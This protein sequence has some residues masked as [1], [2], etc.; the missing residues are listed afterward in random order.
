M[1]FMAILA[2]SF[3]VCYSNTTFSREG[4][5]IAKNHR[6][7]GTEGAKEIGTL[8]G[9][10]YPAAVF[11]SIRFPCGPPQSSAQTPYEKACEI[12]IHSA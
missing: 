4:G 10:S 12:S 5:V 1:V 7:T 11:F 9:Y 8:S 2:F 6:T 3:A